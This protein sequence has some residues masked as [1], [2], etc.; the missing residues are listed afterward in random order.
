MLHA[1]SSNIFKLVPLPSLATMVPICIAPLL[2]ASTLSFAILLYRSWRPVCRVISWAVTFLGLLAATVFI[3]VTWLVLPLWYSKLSAFL[4]TTSQSFDYQVLHM[5]S[6]ST[7]IVDIAHHHV[8]LGLITFFVLGCLILFYGGRTPS[9]GAVT[10]E[11]AATSL[12][13]SPPMCAPSTTDSLTHLLQLLRQP[14][15]TVTTTTPLPSFTLHDVQT[16]LEQTLDSRLAQVEAKMTA[17]FNHEISILA[18]SMA[19]T[20]PTPTTIAALLE[21]AITTNSAKKVESA[22]QPTTL[23][24][25]TPSQLLPTSAT[26]TTSSQDDDDTDS[27]YSFDEPTLVP[28]ANTVLCGQSSRSQ[29]P[30]R[31]LVVRHPPLLKL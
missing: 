15:A 7:D 26:I 11:S 21:S 17:A 14:P 31:L 28:I 12:T 25:S 19:L 10:R 5:A 30:P 20:L 2:I 27:Q 3:R 22:N 8:L 9:N 24:P 16:L 4:L 6:I 1:L 29:N 13:L 18:S 23:P